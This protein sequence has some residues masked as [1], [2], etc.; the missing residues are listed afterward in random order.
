MRQESKWG[1]LLYN[2]VLT[3]AAVVGC[4][5]SLGFG[6]EAMHK[7]HKHKKVTDQIARCDL[8]PTFYQEHSRWCEAATRAG[9]APPSRQAMYVKAPRAE[10]STDFGQQITIR[11]D[12][13]ASNDFRPDGFISLQTAD[14]VAHSTPT[15]YGLFGWVLGTRDWGRR[16]PPIAW[17]AAAER[18]QAVVVRT[19]TT[20]TVVEKRYG[21][22][23]PDCNH[24]S[25]IMRT[26]HDMSGYG[27]QAGPCT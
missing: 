9:V 11:R 22:N 27:K 6:A 1:C 18:K 7:R 14:D 16:N 8:D 15:G 20:K 4:I 24:P 13:Q 25:A 21:F 2:R 19:T 5:I 17:A 10:A 12:P 3:A 26:S 23:D